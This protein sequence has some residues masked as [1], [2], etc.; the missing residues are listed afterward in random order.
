M[1]SSHRNALSK[2]GNIFAS[3]ESCS[4]P[5]PSFPFF[6]SVSIV[7]FKSS[8]LGKNK[9][10][11]SS[12]SFEMATKAST[13]TIPLREA[14]NGDISSCHTSLLDRRLPPK[15]KESNESP[16]FRCAPSA[17]EEEGGGGGCSV[18]S[19]HRVKAFTHAGKS[20][21]FL[22]N[23]KCAMT[24]ESSPRF[25]GLCRCGEELGWARNAA[26]GPKPPFLWLWLQLFPPSA[27]AKSDTNAIFLITKLKPHGP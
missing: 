27:A 24:Q 2:K 19:D 6:V 22:S 3:V 23:E 5:F 25:L 15:G 20:L 1:N 10:I 18:T 4:S 11:S 8:I 21:P 9:S 26:P 17:L 14:T 7:L 12:V 16:S 13:F